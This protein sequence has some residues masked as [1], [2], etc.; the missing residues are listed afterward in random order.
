MRTNDVIKAKLELAKKVTEL[1]TDE[2]VNVNKLD[3]DMKAFTTKKNKG[4]KVVKAVSFTG[5]LTIEF[6]GRLNDDQNFEVGMGQNDID[7]DYMED[8][9]EE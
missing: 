2:N 4:K 5:K 9:E 6:D 8:I 7:N 1:L 3:V